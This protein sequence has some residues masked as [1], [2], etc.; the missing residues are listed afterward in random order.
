MIN[1]TPELPDDTLI[2]FVDL[3]TRIRNALKFAGLKAVGDVRADADQTLLTLQ[4]LG[5]GFSEASAQRA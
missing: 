2:D 5:S 4:D 3:S 1:P